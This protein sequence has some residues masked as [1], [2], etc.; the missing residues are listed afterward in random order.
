[1]SNPIVSVISS[2]VRPHYWMEMHNQINYDA[3]N[4]SFEFVFVGNVRPNFALPENFRHIYSEA[5]PQQC[6]ETACRNA[7]G[8]YVMTVMDDLMFSV[9]FLGL[10]HQ[11]VQRM[12]DNK[13]I[14]MSRF[15]DVLYGPPKD[16]LMY[17][18]PSNK[19]SS[20]IG[21]CTIIKKSVWQELGGYDKRFNQLYGDNDLHL[22]IYE[23]G[24]YPFVVP[25]AIARERPCEDPAKRL[26]C[27]NHPDHVLLN[28][29]W[30]NPDKSLR[31]TRVDTVQPYSPEE[32]PIL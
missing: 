32:I 6:F 2:A 12:T 26:I 4:V 11:Y 16:Y 8:E 29:L 18:D 1:M 13:A 14:V 31:R 23:A 9:G 19:C 27:I 5:K 21:V 24:G 7:K 10:M 3:A 17:F 22:R 28:S 15:S 25:G 30:R 20:V